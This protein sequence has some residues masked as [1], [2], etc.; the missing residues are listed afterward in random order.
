[1]VKLVNVGCASAISGT[2]CRLV[3]KCDP[4][5]LDGCE[6]RHRSFGRAKAALPFQVQIWIAVRPF[7]VMGQCRREPGPIEIV[8]IVE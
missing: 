8:V 2:M 6:Q 4:S 7:E 5:N 3:V 1:M